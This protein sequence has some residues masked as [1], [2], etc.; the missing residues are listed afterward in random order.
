MSA[1]MNLDRIIAAK[2]GELMIANV[3]QAILVET[4]KRELAERES[5]IGDLLHQV[6]ELK[7]RAPEPESPISGG[8]DGLTGGGMG[9]AATE[10]KLGGSG[11]NGHASNSTH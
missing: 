9:G 2:V 8:G 3:K 1:D 6:R 7:A 4:L 5:R 11:G 10:V